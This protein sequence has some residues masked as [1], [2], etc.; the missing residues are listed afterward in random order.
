MYMNMNFF[1][2][3]DEYYHP[4]LTFPSKLGHP[5]LG[6]LVSMG[7]STWGYS[8]NSRLTHR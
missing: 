2:N 8:I 4:L 1:V 5:M 7:K 6:A 3:F